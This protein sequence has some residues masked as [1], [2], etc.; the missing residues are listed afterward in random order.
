M[1]TPTRLRAVHAAGVLVAASVLGATTAASATGGA[2]RACDTP[3]PGHAACMVEIRT[4]STAQRSLGTASPNV[5]TAITG[6]RPADIASAYGLSGGSGG[7]VAIVDA[8][9]NPKLESDLAVYR[10]HWGLAACTT[11]NGCFTKINQRGS[12][13][14][15]PAADEGWGVEEALDVDAVS[16]ACPSCHI[17]VVEADSDSL[18]DLAIAQNRAVKAGAKAVSNSFGGQELTGTQAFATQYYTH[19]GVAQFASTGDNGFP[20]AST[21]AT[22]PGVTAVGGTSLVRASTSRGWKETVWDGAGSGCSAYF[23]KPSWQHD[24]HCPMRTVSDLSAVADPNTGLAI[25]DTFGT[26]ADTPNGWL[27]VGGTSLS[28]PLIAGMVVRSGHA[29]QYSNASPV[30]AHASRFNDVTSGSNG[31]CGGDYLCT[32]KVGYDAPTGVG[33]PKSLASF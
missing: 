21:P 17:L 16:A 29:A 10:K 13:T 2:Q 20:A 14:Y 26:S 7:T 19:P 15:L 18:T 11:A 32:G 6:L 25:Y 1:P 33:T 31:F 24:T 28:T 3:R 5:T 12:R 23:A 22:Y 8:Y 30:Y 9:D 27:Q 4:T